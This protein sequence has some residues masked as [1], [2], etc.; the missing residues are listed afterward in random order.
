MED[1]YLDKIQELDNL[2][3][4]DLMRANEEFVR[5]GGKHTKEEI[6]YLQSAH[7]YKI[8]MAE[9]SKGAQKEEFTRS[10]Q[11]L[12]RRVMEAIKIV[13]PAYYAKIV[14]NAQNAKAVGK[15]PAWGTSRSSAPAGSSSDNAAK[16]GGGTAEDN[17]VSSD[18]VKSWFP[19]KKPTHGFDD[20]AGMQDVVKK[21]KACVGD[22]HRERLAKHLGIKGQKAFILVGPPGCGKTYITEALVKELLE[23][24]YSYMQV[25]GSNI[26]SKYVGDAE[27]IVS[28]VFTE[29]EKHA[30][31]IL[32]IDEIDGVCKNRSKGNLPEYAASLTTSFLIGYN[33][34]KNS[35]KQIYIIGATN[36]PN[37]VD[38]AMLDRVEIIRIGFPDADA[39]KNKLLHS[40]PE[41]LKLADGFTAED[42]AQMTETQNPYNYRDLERLIGTI[43]EYVLDDIWALYGNE[44]MCIAAL[45]SGEY[46]LTREMFAACME[47][48]EVSTKDD[49]IKEIE[50]FFAKKKKKDEES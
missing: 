3:N 37:N 39:R 4:A 38:R 27:K 31:C 9:M 25:D 41:H 7:R 50:D 40:M 44:D 42:M 23:K 34:I 30:P 15:T 14:S 19:E 1:S 18:E 17:V 45:D 46:V 22:A 24:D 6:A 28:R 20:I 12:N 13:E 33:R 10:R 21:M 2:C 29:A 35:E 8:R 16:S 43:Q 26:L 11:E 47:K 36:Y 32:F 49:I 48:C 5:A